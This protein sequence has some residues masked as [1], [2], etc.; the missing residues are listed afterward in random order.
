MKSVQSTLYAALAALYLLAMLWLP[1]PGDAAVKALPIV[2]LA[3]L[4]WQHGARG[5]TLALIASAVGDVLLAYD[6]FVPG[7]AVFLL[8]QLIYALLF[9]RHWLWRSER[10]P[11]LLMLLLWCGAL[12]IAIG[13]NLGALLV[14]VLA[15]L[16][17]IVSMGLTATMNRQAIWPGVAGAACFVLSDSLI[18][19]EMF[20]TVLPGHGWAVMLTYY[21]AQWLL[22][23]A[24]LHLDAA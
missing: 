4:A 16:L 9:A 15:Y 24:L 13:P 8:A 2:Y 5:L 11:L 21:L 6:A 14:P 17:A 18:A 3:V 19:V 7:L 12:F 10:L 22:T 1:F 23:R 20:L